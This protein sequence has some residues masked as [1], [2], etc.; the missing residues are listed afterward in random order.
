MHAT[1]DMARGFESKSVESQQSEALEREPRREQHSADD[2]E[3]R[4]KRESL[5][6]SR[7]RV[8]RELETARTSVHRSA[9]QN[10]LRFLD[11]QLNG[12]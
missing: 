3:R 8:A 10:A 7:A 2:I 9:L 12:M 6:M 1:G 11:D 5:E 4:K